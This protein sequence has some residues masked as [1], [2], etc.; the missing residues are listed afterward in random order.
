MLKLHFHTQQDI[1]QLTKALVFNNDQLLWS[2][3]STMLLSSFKGEWFTHLLAPH[4]I[5]LLL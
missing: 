2:L 4:V 5:A 3:M 1:D